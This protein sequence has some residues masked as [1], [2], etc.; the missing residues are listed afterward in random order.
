MIPYFYVYLCILLAGHKIDCFECNSWNDPRYWVN[1]VS[2]KQLYFWRCG[3]PFN[4]T[5]NVEDMPTIKKCE[6]CC[7]KLVQKI[8]T[9]L[10]SVRRT[11]TDDLGMHDKYTFQ[12]QP[13]QTIGNYLKNTTKWISDIN[14][15][16]VDHVCMA[17]GGGKGHMCF[18]EHD[19][20]NS[21]RKQQ[22]NILFLIG[23]LFVNIRF[24]WI[25][26]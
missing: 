2:L 23:L 3:D 7:V 1:F 11:C 19:D 17:E 14:L 22:N 15:W 26:I 20:C 9:P 24:S 6:G 8:G 5:L 16:L 21:V 4:Y 12:F 25:N 10:Y 18:C 13:F